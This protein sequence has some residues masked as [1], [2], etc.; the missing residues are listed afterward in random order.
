MGQP[1]GCNPIPLQSTI[2]GG[3]VVIQATDLRALA[4]VFER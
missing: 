1:G 3:E 2:G 4:P